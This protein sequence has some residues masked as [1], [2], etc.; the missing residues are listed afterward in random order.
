MPTAMR[1]LG[2]SDE[3]LH[4]PFLTNDYLGGPIL[5]STY[6]HPTGW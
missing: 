5:L 1:L 4:C 2:C 6:L 3:Q